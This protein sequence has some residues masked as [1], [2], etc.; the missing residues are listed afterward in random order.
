MGIDILYYHNYCRRDMPK[1]LEDD[2]PAPLRDLYFIQS[3]VQG[4][5]CEIVKGSMVD[6]TFPGWPIPK[7]LTL[8]LVPGQTID[9]AI[10]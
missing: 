3:H 9:K 7:N 5:W 2:H 4:R 1:V 8:Y 10:R 6:R